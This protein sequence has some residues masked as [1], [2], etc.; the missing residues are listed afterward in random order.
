MSENHEFTAKIQNLGNGY[1]FQITVPKKD[2][3]AG[4]I[5]INKHYRVILIPIEDIKN[6]DK[7]EVKAG[8]AEV[9]E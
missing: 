7:S 2:V 5:N 4:L 6:I 8:P 9:I 3:E 1:R